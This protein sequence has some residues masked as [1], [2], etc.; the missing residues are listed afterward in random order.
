MVSRNS[1][2]AV[3]VLGL[4]VIIGLAS[5]GYLLR[6]A[7]DRFKQYERSVTVK[8][9]AEREYAADVII[10]PLQFSVAGNDL[11]K[12]YDQIEAQSRQIID[13]LTTRGVARE[14]ITRLPPDIGDRS[15]QRYGDNR[16]A[17]FRY[18]A[19]QTLTVYS[20]RVDEVRKLL[21]DLTELGKSGIVLGTGEYQSKPEYVFT[22]L[23]EIK[24]SMIEEATLKAREV[25]MKFAADSGS[26]LGKIRSASQGQFTIA[27]RDSG[28][29][30]I[31]QIRV[32]STVE[33]Y[34]SD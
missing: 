28:N 8:G 30:H 3:L 18:V 10:W 32:V 23:N 33:Y 34:L 25:A 9:L 11:P 4:S 24:P 27:D 15:A 12:L 16:D 5:L 19:Q 22:K 6:D 13:F 17:E 20:P 31:K 7:V 14:E 2:F 21:G 26:R 1:R 29:P